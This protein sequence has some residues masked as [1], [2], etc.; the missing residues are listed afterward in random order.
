MAR[1]RWT[2][3]PGRWLMRIHA[4]ITRGKL[5]SCLVAILWGTTVLSSYA[6]APSSDGDGES[7]EEVLEEGSTVGRLSIRVPNFDEFVLRGNLPVPPGTFPRSDGKD[8]FAVREYDGTLVP[9]QTEIVTRYPG[10]SMGADVVEVI[11]RVRRDP[12]TSS[13]QFGEYEIVLSPH[14]QV[15]DAGPTVT[16][17]D[18]HNT[19][20]DL[21]Q[22]VRDFLTSVGSLQIRSK[23]CFGNGY[24][25]LPLSGFGVR[26][27]VRLGPT[28]SQIRTYSSMVPNTPSN[29][30]PDASLPHFLGVHA[31]IGVLQ[32]EELVS[33]DLRFSNAH[34]G[35]SA[36]TAH[37]DPL[38]PLYFRDIEVVLPQGWN[39]D[40]DVEDPY[41]GAPYFE[42]ANKV[43]PIVR[44]NADGSMH[45]IRWQGQFHRRLMISTT[46]STLRGWSYVTNDMGHGLCVR[47]T[48]PEAGH[49][50]WSWWNPAT[51][52]YFPQCHVLP[53]LDHVNISAL[54]ND[55]VAEHNTLRNYLL[56]GTG[57]GDYPIP[58]NVLGWGHP[59]GV[60]YGGMTGGSEIHLY[61]G[62]KTAAAASPEG[63]KRFQ[64]LHRMHTDR[65][66]SALYDV[67]GTPST[68]EDWLIVVDGGDGDF[69]PFTHFLR[70]ELNANDAFGV[71][72]VDDYQVDYVTA[73][74]LKPG[75]ENVYMSFDPHDYQHF[76]RYTR[77]AKVLLWLGNDPIAK[78]DL[79]MQAE[80]YNLSYHQYMNSSL[81]YIQPNGLRGAM[82]FVDQIPGAGFGFG[83]G[84]GWGLDCVVAA[85]RSGTPEWRARK[86]P[87]LDLIARVLNDGQ[88]ACSG[89]LQAGVT[90][91]FID[92]LYRARQS[93]E[94]S[95]AENA[96][97]GMLQSVYRGVDPAHSAM[98]GSVL[99][100]SLVAFISDMAWW[101][102][103]T[104]PWTHTAVGPREFN[105]PV[106][107]SLSQIPADG[108]TAAHETYLNWSSFAY[109][110]ESTG[111]QTF[112]NKALLQ[113][114]GADLLVGL[115][116]AGVGNLENMAGLLALLQQLNGDI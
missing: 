25:M 24:T 87:W 59:Y 110:Y 5:R 51:A 40:Q 6:C 98:V 89:F 94:Q 68:V 64:V 95:I 19:T 58:T 86:K 75:Y 92:G 71:Y 11:A 90:P 42:G 69:V 67:D 29:G 17:G 38:G 72:Q 20:E 66:P 53:S 91:K 37:D 50:Y 103:E 83:R 31:Y 111:N 3:V 55:L 14:G 70:P 84:E 10:T 80:N 73:N 22:A 60:A 2:S 33:L 47:G 78:D 61:D 1:E 7:G 34:S 79:L 77:A 21:P 56:N 76:I 48:D 4:R 63:Y 97:L 99:R 65:M 101:P 105:L 115:Q 88:A 108:Y 15:A 46:A 8:P 36:A 85:Y 96:I 43:Y 28:L 74:D 23:D 39:L 113:K 93:I 49:K 114:G 18:L 82:G 16:V 52:R 112:L 54:R 9:A 81:G 106:W 35:N 57:L 107:C 116:N 26:E 32:G 45:L 41:F 104:A 13:G 44:P 62:V 12:A 30:G 109:G 100:D 27:V 102:G